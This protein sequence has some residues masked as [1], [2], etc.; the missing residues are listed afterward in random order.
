MRPMKTKWVP[1]SDG[2]AESRKKHEAAFKAASAL[3]KGGSIPW[4][5]LGVRTSGSERKEYN[6]TP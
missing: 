5:G 2:K 4:R 6:P 3:W 1:R